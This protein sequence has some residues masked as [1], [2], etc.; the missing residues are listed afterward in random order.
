MVD[1]T[2]CRPYSSS[3]CVRGKCVRT[4]C[5]GVIGSKLQF[6]KCG[7]C[8]GEGG[9]GGGWI[10][11]RKVLWGEEARSCSCCHLTPSQVAN[12]EDTKKGFC[13]HVIGYARPEVA[14]SKKRLLRFQIS[15]GYCRNTRVQIPSLNVSSTRVQELGV[16][17]RWNIS[18]TKREARHNSTPSNLCIFSG[19]AKQNVKSGD[20]DGLQAKA[21]Y[22][23]RSICLCISLSLKFRKST[24]RLLERR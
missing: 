1:G 5:D 6:D 16:S 17:P 2:E 11:W 12:L 7:V 22:R 8:G 20:Q 24:V 4:G 10:T 23:L 13:R 15:P 21:L 3:V 14:N 18:V 9:G 19:V